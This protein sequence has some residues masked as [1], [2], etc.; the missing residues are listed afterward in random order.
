MKIKKR[1]ASH[2]TQN[3]FSFFSRIYIKFNQ[4]RKFIDLQNCSFQITFFGNEKCG[5]LTMKRY[6]IAKR[7]VILREEQDDKKNRKR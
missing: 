2:Y 1:F 6:G 4:N 5:E 7:K 3:K